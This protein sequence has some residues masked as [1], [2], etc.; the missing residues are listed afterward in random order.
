MPLLLRA[1]ALVACHSLIRNVACSP[2]SDLPILAAGSS[3]IFLV[4]APVFVHWQWCLR[5]DRSCSCVFGWSKDPQTGQ[6]SFS[7]SKRRSRAICIRAFWLVSC[8][9]V[10]AAPARMLLIVV[11]QEPT[12]MNLLLFPCFLLGFTKLRLLAAIFLPEPAFLPISPLLFEPLKVSISSARCCACALPLLALGLSSLIRWSVVVRLF[13]VA[14]LLLAALVCAVLAGS[15][16]GFVELLTS[17]FLFFL[18]PS[19]NARWSCQL[20]CC[21]WILQLL[22]CFVDF[23]S[24]LLCFFHSF[25]FLLHDFLMFKRPHQLVQLCF[26]LSN[27]G[28]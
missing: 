3:S 5:C 26:F 8:F 27:L 18:M 12:R 1:A 11:V 6:G 16:A 10:F 13:Q 2:A 4:F 17:S 25:F 15:A 24:S 9:N 28:F 21:C 14:P 20:T 23:L 19:I 7:S 22:L